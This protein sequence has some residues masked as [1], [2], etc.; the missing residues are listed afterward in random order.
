MLFRAVER[1]GS[2]S[3][4]D[5]L[6][7]LLLTDVDTFS[8][9]LHVHTSLCWLLGIAPL[10]SI[11]GFV[12]LVVFRFSMLRAFFLVIDHALEYFIHVYIM[13]ATRFHD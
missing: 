4:V 3:W 7:M 8:I 11:L 12:L 6:I 10:S 5:S 13:C 2:K 9:Q 1:Y